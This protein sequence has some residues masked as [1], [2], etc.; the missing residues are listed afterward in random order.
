MR[1]FI[2]VDG[3]GAQDSSVRDGSWKA[4]M[5]LAAA[6]LVLA[7]SQPG[8]LWDDSLD[9]RDRACAGAVREEPYVSY[10][11]FRP[12][13]LD[14]DAA[15]SGCR[16]LGARSWSLDERYTLCAPRVCRRSFLVQRLAPVF[17]NDPEEPLNASRLVELFTP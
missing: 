3:R 13:S 1:G 11:F 10:S 15:V 17:D 14:A 4:G 5:L 9:P 6:V 16:A 2:K 12:N 7:R 8:L